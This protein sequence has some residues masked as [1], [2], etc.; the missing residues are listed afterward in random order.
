MHI[1]VGHGRSDFPPAGVLRHPLCQ[2]SQ[3]REANIIRE[4]ALRR[5]L[6]LKCY[7][8]SAVPECNHSILDR[9]TTRLLPK[10]AHAKDH[11]HQ[12]VDGCDRCVVTCA[13][14]S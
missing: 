11:A 6:I 13:Y 14:E 2:S 5:A 4:S 10:I 7:L 9:I 1:V 8:Q 3:R 12:Y